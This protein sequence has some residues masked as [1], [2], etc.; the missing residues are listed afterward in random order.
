MPTPLSIK[1]RNGRT[2]P[3]DKARI[4]NAVFKAARAVGGSDYAEAELV[5]DEVVGLLSI[6]PDGVVPTVEHVQDLVEKALV[7]RGHART[8]KAFILYRD[9]HARIRDLRDALDGAEK[10]VD[11]YLAQSDWRVRE[12]SNMTY[13]LQGLNNHISSAVV[14][15]F[16]LNR[17]YPTEVRQA[18]DNAD[19]HLHD[20][21]LLS[22]YCCGWELRDLVVNGFGGVSGKVESR[23]PKHFR[24]A[25]GQTV[26]FFYTMQGEAAGAQA[27][28][29]F[30]TYLA[31][32][33]RYDKLNYQ[34]VKQALQEFVFNINVPTRVGFQTP[35]TNVTLD[36]N[37][38][39]MLANEN[40]VIGGVEQQETLG[41]FGPEM[42]MFNEAFAEV[43]MSGDAKGRIFS[44]PIPTYNVTKDFDWDSPVSDK[45]F[46]MTARYGL[47]YFSNF[48]NSDMSPEDARSMCCRLR[49]DN[50]ELRKK[51]GGL[52][53][54]NPLTGSIG[55]VTI[56][57]PR[58]GF[59]AKEESAFFERL[60]RL[61]DVARDSL[62]IKRTVLEKFTENN[63]YP[64][65]KHYLRHIKEAYGSYWENHFSTIGLLG[66]NEA[67]ENFLGG[68]IATPEGRAFAIKVLTHMRDRIAEYQVETGRIYNLEATPG[69]GTTYRFAKADKAA[70]P[71]I[72]VANEAAWRDR[73]AA[74][75]Y[76]NSS[77]LPVGHT[78][79]VYAALDHQDDLQALY[80][81][82]TVLHAFLGERM[83]DAR[84][85][86]KLV[87]SI[88]ENYRLPYYTLT[89]TFS[90]CPKHGYLSGEHEYCPTCDSEI[91]YVPKVEVAEVIRA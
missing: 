61:M 74:P 17:L 85:T 81:G 53:G 19:L 29:N 52:F 56:N 46:E 76:T 2:V 13:S 21:G 77:H 3:F 42:D 68:G 71:A 82:G 24:V 22:V 41:D 18:H 55:V 26:N 57:L 91:G 30:D 45:I 49:L 84:S 54:A 66:M 75:Y 78:D 14:S 39:K 90:V 32:F 73:K 36:L 25:L 62:Q 7:E 86:K 67:L 34:E 72:K 51:G 83:P 80:T 8:A 1:K 50:R 11:D 16:W 65:S 12:N 69:E 4:A 33:I 35:F 89:P 38:P 79:D 58:I 23:P 43:M 60:D 15:R 44:F 48:I 47:P 20:L 9:S 88:A 27:F 64:Y 63:L 87:K 31:P 70:Y 5:A 10:L 59:L 6:E 28:S 37:V 40:V